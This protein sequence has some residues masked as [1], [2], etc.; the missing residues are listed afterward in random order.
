MTKNGWKAVSIHTGVVEMASKV[1]R[2]QN[3][4]K[5]VWERISIA[6]FI[7]LAVLEKLQR[8]RLS[9]SASEARAPVLSSEKV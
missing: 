9:A 3:R 5:P 8:E 2:S 1:V 4:N 7:E 6:S